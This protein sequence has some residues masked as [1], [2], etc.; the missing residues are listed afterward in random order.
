MAALTSALIASAL[1]SAGTQVASA[2]M[3]SGAAKDAAK[4]QQ[5]AAGQALAEQER[6][7]AQASAAYAP[8]QALGQQGLSSM[9][10]MLSQ[11]PQP[12]NPQQNQPFRPPQG[13]PPPQM[14][15]PPQR[16]AQGPLAPPM[17]GGGNFGQMMAP[18]RRQPGPGMMGGR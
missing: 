8:Y 15:P 3:Q 17:G 4:S 16:G 10:A 13:A 2:K 14:A 1:I 9:G 6:A 5:Q 7:R 11:R 18:P 12:F